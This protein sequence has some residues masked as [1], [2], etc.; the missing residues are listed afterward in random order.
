MSV[1]FTIRAEGHPNIRATHR[2][3]FEITKEKNLTPKGDCIVGVNAEI[4]ISELP[5][6]IKRL[7]LLDRQV[8]IVL[9]L[10]EYGIKE[11][12][13]AY[14]DSRLSFS[15][16]T[17]I[18]IRKSNYVC[19]RTLAIRANRAAIDF[20]REFVELLKDRTELLFTIEL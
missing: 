10:P 15:H 17:D 13:R 1:K 2:T 14:G 3:T 7:L 8:K 19:G 16:S 5:E 11:T 20:S 18:V 9:E 6:K 4:G 12:V